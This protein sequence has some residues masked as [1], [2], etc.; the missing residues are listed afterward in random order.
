MALYFVQFQNLKTFVL[1]FMPITP[2]EEF[3]QLSELL[4]LQ[5]IEFHIPASDMVV[6]NLA[7]D[8][9]TQCFE[10]QRDDS[11][12]FMVP[13]ITA[14]HKLRW[15]HIG[16][17]GCADLTD[18]FTVNGIALS[19]TLTDVLLWGMRDQLTEASFVAVR[20]AGFEEISAMYT[21]LIRLNAAVQDGGIE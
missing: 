11:K 13:A 4:S 18:A 6:R 20:N 8:M 3:V 12:G 9:F 17:G 5:L 2:N 14:F 1:E 21:K 16:L 10:S 19:E 7:Q 15:L